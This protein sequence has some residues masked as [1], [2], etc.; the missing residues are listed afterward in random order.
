MVV[1][2]DEIPLVLQRFHDDKYA[3]HLGAK[4]TAA[5]VQEN[6]FWPGLERD[7]RRYVAN[8]S[9]CA[10]NKGID[11]PSKPPMTDEQRNV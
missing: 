2:S 8:C 5:R 11:R 10:A 4:K 9:V 6:Y 7:V 1:K 3:A